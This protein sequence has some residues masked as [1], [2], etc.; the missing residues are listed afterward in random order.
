MPVTNARFATTLSTAA[1]TSQA[2]LTA[3][4]K[5]KE[6]LSATVDVGIVFASNHHAA[7]FDRL[8]EI[9]VRELGT[10]CILGCTGESIVCDGQEIE[11]KPALAL[12]IGHLPGVKLTAMH[13]EYVSTPEGSTFVG[14]PDELEDSWPDGASLLVLAEPYSFPA[15]GLLQSIHECRP[16]TAI[17]GGMA[18]G[19]VEP[20]ENRLLLGGQEF[21][22]GAVALLISGK[23]HVRTV[24]SQ[25][26]RPVGKP[27]VVTKAEQNVI[28]ELGGRPALLQLQELFP[29]FTSEDQKL[30]RQGLHLG[31]VINEYQEVFGPGDFL[32]RNVQ[33][34]DP[35]SGAI[36]I[37]DMARVGQTVQFHVRDASTAD[38][39]LK[40][41]LDT[42][43]QQNATAQPIGGLLFTCNGRGTRLFSEPNHDAQA[44][45]S[46]WP[47]LPVAGFFAQGEIGPVGGRSFLHGFTASLALFSAKG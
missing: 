18:S 44:I 29:T 21:E 8:A 10:E 20:G 17:F 41:L 27:L 43:K 28:Y 11:G 22:R 40:T 9:L 13:L 32:I 12:W 38:D 6:K 42:D 30:A 23:T 5:A 25:G 2:A 24:V 26:C 3:C 36:A 7:N 45:E 16:G 19:A 35:K 31:Q 14:W 37:G 47:G 33:G 34:F 4:A 15:D 1:E 46:C 39:E